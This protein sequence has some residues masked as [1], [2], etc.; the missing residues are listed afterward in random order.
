VTSSD[1]ALVFGPD[2]GGRVS[3]TA[4]ML[5]TEVECGGREENPL[6]NESNQSNRRLWQQM[7]QYESYIRKIHVERTKNKDR[8]EGPVEI[9]T[10]SR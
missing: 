4:R 6:M 10:N 1:T 9:K 8:P 2:G 7:L 5:V 3:S